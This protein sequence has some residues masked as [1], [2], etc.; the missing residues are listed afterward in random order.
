MESIAKI[1]SNDRSS[2][3]V[4]PGHYTGGILRLPGR[5]TA[6]APRRSCGGDIDGSDHADEWR[7]GQVYAPDPTTDAE[8]RQVQTQQVPL[9]QTRHDLIGGD[10][11]KPPGR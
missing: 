2:N 11:N 7:Q 8:H 6:A 4:S 10:R 3:A 5:E 1:R 9:G